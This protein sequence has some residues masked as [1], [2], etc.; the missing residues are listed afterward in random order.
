VSKKLSEMKQTISVV[1]QNCR[2]RESE[3]GEN[4]QDISVPEERQQVV[5]A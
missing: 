3:I 4:D 1:Y 2:V 5:T